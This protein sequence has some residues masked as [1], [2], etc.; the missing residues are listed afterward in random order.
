MQSTVSCIVFLSIKM[1]CLMRKTKRHNSQKIWKVEESSTI[2]DFT[3]QTLYTCIECFSEV[4]VQ[5]NQI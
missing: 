2:E 3:F 5:L 1:L 4:S